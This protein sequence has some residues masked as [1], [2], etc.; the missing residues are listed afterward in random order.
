MFIFSIN[1][2]INK[3]TFIASK[4]ISSKTNKISYKPICDK[5]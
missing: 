5:H 2:I 1:T 4:I 3:D